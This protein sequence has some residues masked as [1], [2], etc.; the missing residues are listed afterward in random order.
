MDQK[1]RTKVS[2][3]SSFI[4]TGCAVVTFALG[5]PTISTYPAGIWWVGMLLLLSSGL[6]GYSAFTNFRATQNEKKKSDEL[7]AYVSIQKPGAMTDK[8]KVQILVNW[9]YSSSEWK[10]FLKW[11][12]KKNTPG[13]II[14]TAV[15]VVLA[16]LAIHYLKNVEWLISF[17]IGV[18]FGIAYSII[19]YYLNLSS[20]SMEENKTPEVIITNEAVIINGHLN[21]FYGNNIWLGKITVNDA[22][23][24]NVLEITYCWN[25]RSGQAFNEI[26]VPIPKGS[27]KEAIFLQEQLMAEKI[28]S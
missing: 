21:R 14:E 11:E 16:T 4:L 26:R 17:I 20:L 8:N 27:L 5:I 25:T 3:A 10:E 24:F 22:G 7:A 23:S 1:I 19:K 13:T 2:Q 9:V 15:L 6:M 18:L 28:K 12:N